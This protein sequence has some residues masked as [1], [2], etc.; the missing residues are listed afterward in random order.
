MIVDHRIRGFTLVELLVVLAILAVLLGLVLPAVQRIRESAA[1]LRCANNLKQLALACHA[2]HD[3]NRCLPAGQVGPYKKQPG[4]PYYGW[5]PDSIA[6]SWLARLLPYVEQDNLYRQGGIPAKTLRQSG[7]AADRLTIFLCP[8]D[9]ESEAGPRT[10]AGNL[11]G[12]PVGRASYKGVS[13]AN[14]GYDEGEGHPI[15]TDWPNRGTNGSFDGLIH[16]D[17]ALGRADAF[18]PRRLT[19]FTD[20][21]GNTFLLGEDVNA[22]N[23]WLS[24]P[25]ANNA[26]GTCA[27]PPNAHK[28]DGGAYDPFDWSNVWSFRS[29]HPGGLQFAFADGSVHFVRDSIPL[30]TYRALATI[31]GGEVV[32]PGGVD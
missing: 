12:F 29:R 18:H 28:P 26:Y 21:T 4:Q 6:W 22:A 15:A 5:G 19:D 9:E 7:I 3:P 8:S 17:G 16:G 23:R 2:Y 1:R 10:E 31:A 24:W 11:E 27:I 25:Y 30:S 14:W 13:G 32:D 20:G